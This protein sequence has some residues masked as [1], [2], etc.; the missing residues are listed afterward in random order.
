[1]IKI[2]PEPWASNSIQKFIQICQQN[3][4]HY[5][6]ADHIDMTRQTRSYP[7]FKIKSYD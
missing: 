3:N 2:M 6:L 7:I 4:I 1:M 5:D